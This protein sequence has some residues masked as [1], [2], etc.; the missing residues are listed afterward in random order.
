MLEIYTEEMAADYVPL[1]LNAS[2]SHFRT[3]FVPYW[4]KILLQSLKSI[5]KKQAC[6]LS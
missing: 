6:F 4:E 3:V 1:K 5:T 2:E